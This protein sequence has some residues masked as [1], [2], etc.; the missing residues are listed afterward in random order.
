[1]LGTAGTIG[2]HRLCHTVADDLAA[3]NRDVVIVHPSVLPSW[4]VWQLV[5]P[6][7]AERRLHMVV[8]HGP[9]H[10]EPPVTAIGNAAGVVWTPPNV[11]RTPEHLAMQRLDCDVVVVIGAADAACSGDWLAFALDWSAARRGHEQPTSDD[12]DQRPPP[13]LCLILSYDDAGRLGPEAELRLAVH[14]WWGLDGSPEIRTLCR[15]VR[16]GGANRLHDLWLENLT[17][18]L[19]GGDPHLAVQLA[20]SGSLSDPDV[21]RL[22]RQYAEECSW[23]GHTLGKVDWDAAEHLCLIAEATGSGLPPP[24]RL[25]PLWSTGQMYWTPDFGAEVHSAVLAALGRWDRIQHRMWRAHIACTMPVADNARR[26]LCGY[27]AEKI[28]TNWP[29]RLLVPSDAW[30]EQRVLDNPSLAQLGYLAHLFSTVPELQRSGPWKR[31]AVAANIVRRRVA[32]FDT[33]EHSELYNVEMAI[34]EVS[35]FQR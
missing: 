21:Q 35:S 33:I 30:D 19:A 8:I 16:K 2:A 31:L 20:L 4:E 18:S 32:H 27:L 25:R 29:H 10:A 9:D 24:A 12:D 23:T 11:T 26:L 28:G 13:L 3:R 22:L 14:W 1:M 7:L 15:E 6:K 17:V 5:E 34:A